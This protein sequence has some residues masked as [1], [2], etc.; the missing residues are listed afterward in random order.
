MPDRP[1]VI[2][3]VTTLAGELGVNVAD[4]EIAHSLEGGAGVLVMV[5]A[6]VGADAFEDGPAGTRLPHQPDGAPVSRMSVPDELTFGGVRPLRGTHP[7][8]RRQV[9][10]APRPAL[11][12]DRGRTE[13]AVAPRDRGR[14]AGDRDRSAAA[15][16]E[17]PHRFGRDH[18]VGYRVRTDGAKPTR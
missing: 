9:D 10:L 7:R 3:E 14:R 1:G 17:G 6:A 12:G 15:R 13:H 11:R 5:V 16:R 18:R 2:S 8:A 4:F